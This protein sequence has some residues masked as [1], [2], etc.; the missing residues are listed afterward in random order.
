MSRCNQAISIL[1][2]VLCSVCLA[3]ISE[4]YSKASEYNTVIPYNSPEDYKEVIDALMSHIDGTISLSDEELE[5]NHDILLAN[6]DVLSYDIESIRMSFDLIQ[7]F[8]DSIGPLFTT[9]NT[10][11]GI[12][13]AYAAD[14]LNLHRN[15]ILVHQGLIDHSYS[16]DI[17]T[18]F[19]DEL[20]G[21]YYLSSSYFPGAVNPPQDSNVLE[22]T[23]IRCSYMLAGGSQPWRE[24]GNDN[25]VRPTGCY[26]A[27][28]SIAE[29]TVPESMVDK[30]IKVRVG[31]H[32]WDLQGKN[33]YKRLDRVG[34]LY[35][36]NDTKVKIAHPLGGG[37][38][39]EIP[40]GIDEGL[41]DITLQN[42]VRA[43]FFSMKSFDE[44]TLEEW[45]NIERNHPAPWADFETDKFMMQV[46]TSWIYA[47]DDPESLLKDWDKSMDAVSD[48]LGR[49]RVTDRH[50]NYLQFDVIIRGSAYH[51]GYPMSN[52]PY[53]PNSATDGTPNHNILRG[54][55]YGQDIHF[56]ELGH[57]VAI[58]KFAGE[59]EAIVNFLYVPVLNRCFDTPLGEAF[60]RSFG[61]SYGFNTN[62]DDITRTRLVANSFHEGVPRNI[63]GCTQNEVRYQHRGY[64]HYV[65]IVELYGWEAL[66]TFWQSESDAADMGNPYPVNNQEQDDRIFRM[67]LAAG[68]DL[69]PLFHFWGIHPNDHDALVERMNEHGLEL[70]MDI[71]AKLHHYRSLIPMNY[72]EFVAFGNDLYPDFLNYSGSQFDFGE[73]WYQ[74]TAEIYDDVRAQEIVQRLS[75]III[76]YYGTDCFEE[77]EFINSVLSIPTEYCVSDEL[78]MLPDSSE[79]GIQGSW[80]PP[81]IDVSEA[82]VFEYVFKPQLD[83]CSEGGTVLIEVFEAEVNI[84]GD[85]EFCNGEST[86]LTSDNS[87]TSYSWQLNG[88]QVGSLNTITIDE[89]GV[90]HLIAI[91][92]NGC[93]AED[94]IIVTELPSI[95]VDIVVDDV[96]C[97]GD[98]GGADFEANNPNGNDYEYS[99]TGDMLLAGSY[100]VTVTDGFGCSDVFDFEVIQPDSLVIEDIVDGFAVITGGVLP[101]QDVLYDTL[102][103]V[104]TVT[105]IDYL[106]CMASAEFMLT[107]VNELAESQ[108][109]I[110]PNPALDLVRIDMVEALDINSLRLLGID[111]RLVKE[112]SRFQSTLNVSDVVNGVYLLQIQ[113]N[114]GDLL[115]SKLIIAR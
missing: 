112:Y 88:L 62:K 38:Y 99:M 29:I 36:I 76:Y 30:G 20:N 52:T 3:P 13:R 49:P 97:Y 75:D 12:N 10:R 107:N 25:V 92:E 22:T 45:Q 53:N 5:N 106:G 73:G 11:N 23:T 105:V 6:L 81:S 84:S 16:E 41:Q 56:H 114:E 4:I 48:L 27:P 43:P 91:D 64:A 61:P 40:L 104:I 24:I 54:P 100:T 86:E 77:N 26:L 111:G 74:Q 46:P 110:Y 7:Q 31:A 89:G 87:Y 94:Q 33:N 96:D 69:R 21:K 103:N 101:Y 85:S 9:N 1:L 34:I 51:P 65:D 17:L 44:T 109:K 47:F 15:L 35:E 32:F 98:Y 82:G 113:T 18:N 70:P 71:K 42:V 60:A 59:V 66:E 72:D 93:E 83:Q 58:T 14:G 55:Q 67:S 115:L 80:F 39:I 57:E 102:D 108:I 63:C 37:I 8:E 95:E 79:N 28:G 90:V 19:P 2:F 50:K 78:I 68:V